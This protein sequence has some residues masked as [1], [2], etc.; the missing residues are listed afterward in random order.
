MRDKVSAFWMQMQHSELAETCA[1]IRLLVLNIVTFSR[2]DENAIKRWKKAGGQIAVI[3]EIENQNVN[4][5]VNRLE[6][7]FFFSGCRDKSTALRWILQ[8][9]GLKPSRVATFASHG[10]DLFL[11]QQ[12]A[13]I[14]AAPS[15]SDEFLRTA[16]FITRRDVGEGAVAEACGLL[17]RTRMKLGRVSEKW[18]TGTYS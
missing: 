11:A 3:T 10:S 16:H 15:A 5:V 2:R 14:F 8:S 12:G 13:V 9:Q 7:D 1:E 18:T 4:D 17:F 6:V